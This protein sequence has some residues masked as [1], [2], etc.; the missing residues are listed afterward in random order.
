MAFS[1][2]E[3]HKAV[4]SDNFLQIKKPEVL[5]IPNLSLW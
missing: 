3:A 4:V 2:A 1:A 5:L